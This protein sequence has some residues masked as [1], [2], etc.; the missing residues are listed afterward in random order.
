[1][2]S[3]SIKETNKNSRSKLYIITD[4]NTNTFVKNKK[5]S[6]DM[7]NINNNTEFH[8]FTHLTN[9]STYIRESNSFI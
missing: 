8:D 4:H 5:N 1:M 9:M 7:T 6:F 3:I 2:G